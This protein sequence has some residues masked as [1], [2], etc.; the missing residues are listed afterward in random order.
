MLLGLS[1]TS[2]SCSKGTS[3]GQTERILLFLKGN[4]HPYLQ[5]TCFHGHISFSSTYIESLV[6]AMSSAYLR[7]CKTISQPIIPWLP[8]SSASWWNKSLSPQPRC[9]DIAMQMA[10]AKKRMNTVGAST[11]PYCA[12]LLTRNPSETLPCAHTVS[13]ASWCR[14]LRICKSLSETLYLFCFNNPR[15]IMVYRVIGLSQVHKTVM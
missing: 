13:L 5:M 6:K 12:P 3:A 15:C 4:I 11:S 10:A 1:I 8:T 2:L 14:A 9:G 7:F